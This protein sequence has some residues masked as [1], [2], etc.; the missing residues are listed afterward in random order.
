MCIEKKIIRLMLIFAF[1]SLAVVLA[2]TISQSV[3]SDAAARFYV[4]TGKVVGKSHAPESDDTSVVVVSNGKTTY[5]V[6]VRNHKAESW[7]VIVLHDGRVFS[8]V[9]SSAD[10]AEIQAGKAVD[11]Y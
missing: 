2:A 10:W 7:S 1:G 9:V 8:D 11:V 5:P 6:A 3:C 4:G